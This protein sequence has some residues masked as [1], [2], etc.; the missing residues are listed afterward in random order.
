[1]SIPIDES[2]AQLALGAVEHRRQQVMAEIGVPAWYV[3]SAAGEGH[4]S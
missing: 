3:S 4:R 2:E 1:M